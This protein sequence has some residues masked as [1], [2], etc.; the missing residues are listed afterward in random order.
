MIN[1]SFFSKPVSGGG[2]VPSGTNTG[3]MIR[4]NAGT[5]AYE[6][7]AEPFIFTQINLTPAA[8]APADNK[9]GMYYSNVDDSIYVCTADA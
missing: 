1:K 7:K 2:S 5:G 9:G 4:W 3:D 6:V 8:A